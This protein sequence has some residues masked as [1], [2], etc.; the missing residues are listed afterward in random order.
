[1]APKKRLGELLVD[2]G[3]IDQ[4]QLQAALAYQKEWGGRIG[5][6]L[7]RRGFVTDETIISVIEQQLGMRCLTFE[8]MSPPSAEMRKLIPAETAE[9]FGI[10]PVKFENRTL[11]IATA[12]PTDLKT[13]DDLSF[14]LGVRIKPVLAHDEDIEDAI[15]I[16]YGPR[17]GHTRRQRRKP[18]ERWAGTGERATGE[19]FEIVRSHADHL[20]SSKV[21]RPSPADGFDQQMLAAVIDLL[22]EK[23]VIS[24]EELLSRLRNRPKS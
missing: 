22:V 15:A 2:A 5:T 21:Q 7:V 1:M 8:Q 9:R 18:A 6:I 13:L 20:E 11:E 17:P 10:Y 14:Q 4:L 16:Y 3:L 23:G 12:D 19:E 24:H